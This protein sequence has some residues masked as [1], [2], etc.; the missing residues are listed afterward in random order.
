MAQDFSTL[1]ANVGSSAARDEELQSA[2][3]PTTERRT[4]LMTTMEEEDRTK[5][6]DKEGES[7]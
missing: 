3:S 1:S 7:V 5:T 6:L 4:R 2:G